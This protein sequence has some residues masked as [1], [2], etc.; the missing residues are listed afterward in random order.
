MAFSGEDRPPVQLQQAAASEVIGAVAAR[1]VET[2]WTPERMARAVPVR[3]RDSGGVSSAA[4]ERTAVA[5]GGIPT[6]GALFF[7]NGSGDRYCTGAVVNS[8]SRQLVITAAHCVHGGKGRGYYRNIAFVPKYDRGKRPYGVWTARKLFV[9]RLWATQSDVDLD[10]A[11][12]SLHPRNGRK[13]QHVV[14]ANLIAVNKGYV[15]TV[16]VTGYPKITRD[17]RDRP[18]WCRTTTRKQ[19]RYQIRMECN[20]F[21]GGTSGSPWL[22]RYDSSSRTG[23]INAVL[24]GYQGGGSVHWISYA[25]YFDDDLV[26]LRNYASNHA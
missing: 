13:I 6:V 4:A 24:G 19:A 14:G 10:Y 17:R 2:Y 1:D 3:G 9:H 22:L 25:S 18:I 26:R 12:I 5:Y 23:Y 11:F 16:T 7:N 8:P 15:N 20:G 21:Y